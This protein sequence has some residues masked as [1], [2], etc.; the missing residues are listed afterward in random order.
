MERPQPF[1]GSS[2]PSSTAPYRLRR[3]YPELSTVPTGGVGIRNAREYLDHGAVAVGV[4]G[5]PTAAGDATA[6]TEAARRLLAAL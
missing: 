6:I 1:E 5:S 4:V 2:M 3:F